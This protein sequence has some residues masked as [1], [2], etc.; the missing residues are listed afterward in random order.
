MPV[1]AFLTP[2]RIQP[3]HSKI[4]VTRASFLLAM[5]PRWILD[6]LNSSILIR[7]EERERK[8][9]IEVTNLKSNSKREN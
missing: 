7:N 1:D 6:L 9:K 5:N 4:T 3:V 2:F 8:K